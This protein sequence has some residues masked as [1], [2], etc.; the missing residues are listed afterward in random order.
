MP[1]LAQSNQHT[2]KERRMKDLDINKCIK[3]TAAPD[4]FI[5]LQNGDQKEYDRLLKLELV[6]RKLEYLRK[7]LKEAA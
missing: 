7:S 3:R 6:N 5:V 4:W 2:Q 1:A